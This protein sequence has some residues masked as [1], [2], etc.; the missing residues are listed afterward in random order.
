MA[1]NHDPVL[2]VGERASVVIVSVEEWPWNA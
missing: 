2:V 1:M